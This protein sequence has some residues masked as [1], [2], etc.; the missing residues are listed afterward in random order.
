MNRH[1]G[2]A[3]ERL[4]HIRQ[5]ISDILTT[6]LGSRLMRR[7]YGSHLPDLIDAPHNDHTR[8]LALAAIAAAVMR[9]EPRVRISRAQIAYG[10]AWSTGV[11]DIEGT[12][13]DS[14]EPFSLQVPLRM[15]ALA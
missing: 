9:W 1:N 2:R 3:I 12:L 14:N 13:V 4:A 7:E 15:G 5:S 10:D 6:P 11:A 8:M